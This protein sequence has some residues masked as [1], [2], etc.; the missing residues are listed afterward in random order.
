MKMNYKRLCKFGRKVWKSLTHN[1]RVNY[2]YDT[3]TIG[4]VEKISSIL[5][6]DLD[7]FSQEEFEKIYEFIIK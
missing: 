4:F 1:E 2:Y 5:Y 3:G 6:I 7:E